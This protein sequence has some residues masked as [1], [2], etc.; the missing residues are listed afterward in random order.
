M[1]AASYV[2][3]KSGSPQVAVSSAAPGLERKESEQNEDDI[4]SECSSLRAYDRAPGSRTTG[5]AGEACHSKGGCCE[6]SSSIAAIRL[7]RTDERLAQRRG[8]K[9]HVLPMPVWPRRKGA[10]DAL[11]RLS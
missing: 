7:D 1:Y 4:D 6:E 9:D 8:E 5:P 3:R 11:G 2:V 10:E